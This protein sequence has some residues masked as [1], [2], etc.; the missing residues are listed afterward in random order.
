VLKNRRRRRDDRAGITRPVGASAS[1]ANF[2]VSNRKDSDDGLG[3]INTRL[4][5]DAAVNEPMC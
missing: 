2:A 3:V 1:D 5:L 4:E